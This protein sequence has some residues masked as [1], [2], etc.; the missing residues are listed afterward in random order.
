MQRRGEF[1]YFGIVFN[2]Y[3]LHRDNGEVGDVE[4]KVSLERE[5]EDGPTLERE[6]VEFWKIRIN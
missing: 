6:G 4:E 2:S 5:D 1:F 3:C